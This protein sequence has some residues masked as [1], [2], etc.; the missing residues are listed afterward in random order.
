MAGSSLSRRIVVLCGSPREDG[1][2]R[3]L[4]ESVLVGAHRAGHAAEL[5][6]LNQMMTGMLRDCRRCRLSDGRCR[7]DD[8]YAE[9]IHEHVLPARALVYATPLYWYGMSAA[10]KN[11]FDRLVCYIS[12]SY[13][14]RELVVEGLKNK[15]V[16]LLI[17][18]EER[19]PTAGSAVISQ[20]QE[21]SRYFQQQFVATVNGIANKRGEVRFD[22]AKPLDAARRLG[23]DIFD[24]HHSDYDIDADRPNAVWVEA[25]KTVHDAQPSPYADT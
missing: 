17:S 20:I 22:P 19:Y 2:S 25:Q 12:A 24:L 23:A 3:M 21:I 16:A 15:R 18:S 6:D 9:L 13:P 5:I 11:Y 10:M 14:Q 8:R 1:N 4:G 7:I